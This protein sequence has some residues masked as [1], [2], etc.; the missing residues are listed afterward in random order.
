MQKY[1]IS[2]HAKCILTG[3][4]A[5]LRACPAIVF[6]LLKKKITLSYIETDSPATAEAESAYSE[7]LKLF[8]WGILEA[9]LKQLNKNHNDISGEFSI[10]NTI[11]MGAGLGFSAAFCASIAQWFLYK[12]WIKAAQLMEFA[13][14]LENGFHGRS[15]GVDIA[16][17]LASQAIRFNGVGQTRPLAL[18]WQP[19]L[20]LSYSHQ[21]SVTAKCIEA[22]DTLWLSDAV[23]A[24][25]IDAD[26]RASV[27]MAERS[28]CGD[29]RQ[30]PALLK[31]AIDTAEDCFQ[32]WGLI[33]TELRAHCNLLRTAGAVAVKPTGAGEGGYVLS[34]W[35][36]E[37][38]FNL[39]FECLP[40]LQ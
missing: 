15:S 21:I 7:T 33:S 31:T 29:P 11:P 5:V 12:G 2:S 8:F 6:P 35:E 22:V 23:R 37:P 10:H 40:V 28:L 4:H 27:E 14:K 13:R 16:G 1:I 24:K 17:A 20:Y 19:K 26:M 38:P 32:R 30:G 3:E 34:L 36:E 9:A 18:T 39:G 25:K